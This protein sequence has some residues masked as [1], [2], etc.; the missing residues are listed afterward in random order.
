MFGMSNQNNQKRTM[1]YGKGDVFVFRTYVKPLTGL[2]V[3][4]ESN[5]TSKNNVIFGMNAQ[6]ALKGDAFLSSFTEGD[7]SLVIAT[8]S[9]KNFMLRQAANYEGSTM[10]GFLTFVCERFLDKYS[11]IDA[12]RISA[13]EV[14]FDSVL[15][16]SGSTLEHS[17]VVYRKSRN[18]FATAAV[19][20]ERT[21]TGSKIIEQTSG[22][23]EVH[24]IKVKGSSFY[25]YIHDEY[26]TL[27]E[28]YDRPLF[29]YL[30][31]DWKYSNIVDAFGAD[32]E[33]YVAAEQVRD[34]AQSVF[35]QL[36]NRSIQQLIYH[37]GLRV[38]D[39]FPQLEEVRFGTNNRTWETIVEN[40]PN[41]EGSVFT[42]PRP[43]YGFQ[44]FAVTREDLEKEKATPESAYTQ[45]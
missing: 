40:I 8:D 38:L 6:I 12:V 35:H 2:K 24:L 30:N 19:E 20:V 13:N 21:A 31:I 9:M 39:R 42:E 16:P 33:R 26:T 36:D 11:H 4:P 25:G 18:E 44:G 3:I 10:E 45:V 28:A 1:F 34:I 23:S 43:P 5:F 15:V 22:I 27:P 7:N 17:D 37:I 29:I 32:P 41:S 14:P